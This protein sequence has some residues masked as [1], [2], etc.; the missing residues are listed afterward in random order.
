[1]SE[2]TINPSLL[3]VED[4]VAA[5]SA[6]RL[7]LKRSFAVTPAGTIAEARAAIANGNFDWI[8]LDLML[9][10]GSGIEILKSVKA[11]SLPTKVVVMT[12]CG[13]PYILDTAQQLHPSAILAKPFSFP[14]LLSILRD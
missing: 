14:S 10:D 5:L 9:P 13:D 6:L 4:D 7:L 8:L 11:A 2:L 1:V 3:I 12:G